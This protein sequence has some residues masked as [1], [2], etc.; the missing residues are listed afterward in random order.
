MQII[1]LVL[2]ELG[3]LELE[4]KLHHIAMNRKRF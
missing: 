4:G 1:E 2:K 3:D